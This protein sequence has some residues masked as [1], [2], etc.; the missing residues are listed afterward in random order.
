M[1]VTLR[2]GM[3]KQRRILS[4]VRKTTVM[5]VLPPKVVLALK[6]LGMKLLAPKPVMLPLLNKI[7]HVLVAHLTTVEGVNLV[8]PIAN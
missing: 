2:D 4:L 8:I 6:P 1:I 5:H 7:L 3:I